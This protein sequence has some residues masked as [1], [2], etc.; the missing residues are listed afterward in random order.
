MKPEHDADAAPDAARAHARPSRPARRDAD[1]RR[2]ERAL[3]ADVGAARRGD[4]RREHRRLKPSEIARRSRPQT[5]EMVPKYLD[6]EAVAVVQGGVPETT[7]LL[8]AEVGPDLL[9]RQPAGREDRPQGGGQE[10]HAG[11]AGARRQEPDDRPLVR[12]HEDGGPPHR[13]RAVHQLG[14]DLHRARTT[15]SSG[16]RSRTSSSRT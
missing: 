14:A 3:H 5:A 15:C 16:P 11:G 10:S 12:G 13:L 4:R 9:H 2:L 7:A 6:P 1:H 8:G